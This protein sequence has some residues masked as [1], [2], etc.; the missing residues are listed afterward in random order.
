VG[1]FRFKPEPDLELVRRVLTHPR[2]YRQISDDGS[3]P[4]EEF[5]PSDHPAVTYLMAYQGEELLGL[6]VL[7][8]HNSVCWEIHVAMLPTAWGRARAA[9]RALFAWLWTH[10]PCRRLVA[11]IPESNR[12]ALAL[13]LDTGMRIFGFNEKSFLR[14]GRLEG[15]IMLGLSRPDEE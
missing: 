15:Q 13:A 3:P 10:T 7:V 4:P 11:S 2:I 9:T 14:G 5:Q 12:L 6:Y 1:S 8:P